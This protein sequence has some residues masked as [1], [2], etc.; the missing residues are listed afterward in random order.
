MDHPRVILREFFFLRGHF[1]S[2]LFS[3]HGLSRPVLRGSP[4]IDR[5]NFNAIFAVSAKGYFNNLIV[6]D[7]DCG[8]GG[9]RGGGWGKGGKVHW[10]SRDVLE[11]DC[12]HFLFSGCWETTE[13]KKKG[14]ISTNHDSYWLFLIASVTFDWRVPSALQQ[15]FCNGVGSRWRRFRLVLVGFGTS[16]PRPS[17]GHRGGQSAAEAPNQGQ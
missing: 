12:G 5:C 13:K 10:N 16:N 7:V 2:H 3:S 9:G 14:T 15:L 11:R 1:P 8:V 17:W 4:P 6:V